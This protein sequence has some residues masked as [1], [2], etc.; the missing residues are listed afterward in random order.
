MRRPVS[1]SGV[2]LPIDAVIPALRSV[3]SVGT[4]AV[5]Q[6]PPGAGKT[7]RVP[8]AL[9]YEPWLGGQRILMLEPRRLATRAVATHMASLLGENVGET[10]G[11]RVRR[12]S[13]V[14]PQTRI[15]VVTEGILTRLLQ[16]DPTL[17]GIGLLIFDEFHE[18]SVH[19]DLGLAL[20]LHSRE[21]VRPD[22]RILVM[23][24]T[25][26]GAAVARML[27]DAPIVASEGRSFPVDVRYMDGP[28]S[29]TLEAAVVT[30]IERGLEQ[31]SGD[32][33]VFLP[34]GREIRRVARLLGERSLPH[35]VDVTPLYGDL[36]LRAQDAA[37]APAPEGRRK[38]VLST[39]IAETSL[40]IEGVTVVVDSGL[41]RAPSFSARSGMSRLQTIRISRSSAD[42]RS[43]RAGRVRPGV[44]YRLWP[45][46]EQHHLAEHS[47]PEI[48]S[49][50][51]A[52]LALD[53][54]A[55]GIQNPA[56]LQWLDAPPSAAYA[57]A[58]GLLAT[59]GALDESGRITAH[60]RAM[61]ALPT[62]PRIAHMLLASKQ[63]GIGA[64]ACDIAALL[65][66]RDILRG[67]GMPPDA[68]IRLR[69]DALQHLAGGG[70]VRDVQHGAM[71]DVGL[72]RRVVTESAT[73]RRQLGVGVGVG[74]GAGVKETERDEDA[75]G[76]ALA[77][78][79]PDRIG[80]ARGDDGGAG[81]FLLRN[82]RGAALT[83]AQ[84]LSVAEYVVA[85]DLD[86]GEREA[87][88][89]LGAPLTEL[90]VRTH[91]A[92]EIETLDT[93]EWDTD[94]MK[95]RGWR[96]ERLDAIVL[97]ESRIARPERAA[98]A[99]VLAKRIDSN[100]PAELTWSGGAL[101]LRHRMAFVRLRDA[102]W[103]DVSDKAITEH[104]RAWLEQ[105]SDNDSAIYKAI[106]SPADIDVHAILMGMLDWKQRT[107]LER[108]APTH[109]VTPAG[110][111]V[112]IDYS[113][114]SAPTI[115]VRLQEMFGEQSTPTVAGGR[116]PLT[117]QL[118][119]PARRPVQVT[120]DLAG[121][122]KGSYFDVRKELRGRY[123]KHS[124]PDDPLAAP[125]TSRAK[126]RRE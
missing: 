81:R 123:P 27:G 93:V 64:L 8:L 19:A 7:T 83:H 30:H 69:L 79:Y 12:D 120:R 86:G 44:C 96:T 109:Y 102:E 80:R 54:A 34:G 94:A 65:G 73:L 50:D 100:G 17:D 31:D 66:E 23:S 24:A 28:T 116:V 89:F 88:I 41:V 105:P 67:D 43:G 78:A 46:H 126:R 68:D 106:D 38:V 52:P 11:Y 59:L 49:T 29:R 62:H 107:E 61:A 103:P 33:L 18:R 13:R 91:F 55:A 20:A 112:V 53:L 4:S 3:L 45:A 87:R 97:R 90:E 26:D 119:S 10:V 57:H 15:E 25:L 60:G 1:G 121:F 35:G 5:L 72:A 37:I 51:I 76:V 47:T 124:W 118:L 84:S 113:D 110:S 21:L 48:L 16:R 111:R 42:Q 71:L 99:R 32:V 70:P 63:L 75:A 77:L 82:G 58:R 36:P 74:V 2:S 98:I 101:S 122:W 9:V 114:P 22:L 117:V 6:A 104:V 14:G 95:V 125:P 85:A 40:T 39:P 92:D 56:E 108:V 115:A